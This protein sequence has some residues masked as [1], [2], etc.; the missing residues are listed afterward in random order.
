MPLKV[1]VIED[2]RDLTGLLQYALE[3]EGF[4]FSGIHDGLSA[5]DF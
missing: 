1:A 5:T 2:D 3:Q 4:E